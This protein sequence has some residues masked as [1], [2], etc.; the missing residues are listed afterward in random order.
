M[1]ID[2]DV[3]YK[4]TQAFSNAKDNSE[5]YQ[6]INRLGKEWCDECG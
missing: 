5:D 6:S 1:F 4:L 3:V 2:M